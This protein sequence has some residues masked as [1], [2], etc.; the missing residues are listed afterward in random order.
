MQLSQHRKRLAAIFVIVALSC[1]APAS[2][3]PTSPLCDDGS[4][5]ARHALICD[6]GGPL[7]GIGSGGGG[8]G[9]GGLLGIIGRA[10]HGL[11]GGLL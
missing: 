8:A 2:A 5:R 1:A 9:G 4:Y 10:L 3:D 7:P 11:T 6:T